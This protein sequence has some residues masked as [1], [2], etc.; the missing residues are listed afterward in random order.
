MGL[1]NK[2]VYAIR[3]ASAHSQMGCHVKDNTL[4]YRKQ[5]ALPTPR[6]DIFIEVGKGTF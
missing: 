3:A 5:M 2:I 4:P 6:G 1:P